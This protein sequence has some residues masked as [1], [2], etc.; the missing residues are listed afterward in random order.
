MLYL[1]QTPNLS[2]LIG[3]PRLERFCDAIGKSKFAI[4]VGIYVGN[5]QQ[6][7][8]TLNG[9]NGYNN[10]RLVIKNGLRMVAWKR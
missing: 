8:N 5:T 6:R 2:R 10:D 9:T 7:D 3:I 1:P 4:T